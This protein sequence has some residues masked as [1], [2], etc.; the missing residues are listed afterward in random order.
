[1]LGNIRHFAARTGD[2]YVVRFPNRNGS[3]Y[4]LPQRIEMTISN[5]Y[6]TED[7]FILG[8]SFDGATPPKHVY[9]TSWSNRDAPANWTATELTQTSP[10]SAV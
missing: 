3:G 6:R 5:A 8:V 2:R 1:M 9:L 7:W 10:A 4:N